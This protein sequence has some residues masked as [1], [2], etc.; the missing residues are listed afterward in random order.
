M[1]KIE[2]FYLEEDPH[3]EGFLISLERS[4]YQGNGVYGGLLFAYFV[5]AFHH[6]SG[7]PIRSLQVEL[8]QPLVEGGARL[9]VE[10]MR[11][12]SQTDFLRA[13]LWQSNKVVAMAS[14]VMGGARRSREHWTEQ[15][16]PKIPSFES[17]SSIPYSPMMPTF[18]QH[19]DYRLAVGAAPF[20]RAHSSH[21]GGWIAFRDMHSDDPYA[22][23]AALIDAW[24]PSMVLRFS[25]MMAMG[26]V[27]FSCHF[28]EP[29][30]APY[31][32]IA[33][34]HKI[35]TGYASEYNQL[36]SASGQLVAQAQQL[37]V[38]V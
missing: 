1:S 8:C 16:C 36:W 11:S 5:R 21:T 17:L 23:Q 37:I 28:F 6:K 15:V 34:T 20:S 3:E 13:V 25:K 7:Y 14:A 31:I 30:P 33:Q 22:V 26:T 32:F 24:W 9:C 35:D 38:I 27:S 19:V 10:R 29:A 18:C 12:G 2:G 4:W